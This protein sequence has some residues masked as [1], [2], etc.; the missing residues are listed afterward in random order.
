MAAA[1]SKVIDTI[2]K[3]VWVLIMRRL[4]LRLES[5]HETITFKWTNKI[6]TQIVVITQIV[7]FQTKMDNA[8]LIINV[9]AAYVG[10][11]EPSQNQLHITNYLLIHL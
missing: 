8:S 9:V 2:A 11:I 5:S 1:P 3:R 4:Q 7:P 6:C 10:L